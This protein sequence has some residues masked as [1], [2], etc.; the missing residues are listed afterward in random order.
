MNAVYPCGHAREGRN[1]LSFRSGAGRSARC[2]ECHNAYQNAIQKAGR[3]ALKLVIQ[4]HAE[5]LLSEGQVAKATG[6]DRVHIRD[7]TG[8]PA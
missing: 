1:V 7:L 3:G 2:R 5:G 4:M 8:I 6:L